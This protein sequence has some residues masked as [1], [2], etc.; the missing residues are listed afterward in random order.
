VLVGIALPAAFLMGERAAHGAA[1]ARPDASPFVSQ[2]AWRLTDAVVT[3]RG[4]VVA[5]R[6]G[7]LVSG[8]TVHATATSIGEGRY[9]RGRFQ[10]TGTL[11][12]PSA[13]SGR[14]RGGPWLVNGAWDVLDPHLSTEERGRSPYVAGG[15]L[16]AVLPF[17]PLEAPGMIQA[18]L[19]LTSL[20]PAG[21]RM[22]GQGT[23]SGNERFEGMLSWKVLEPPEAAVKAA[24]RSAWLNAAPL[25]ESRGGSAAPG[26]AVRLLREAMSA[27]GG[28]PLSQRSAP[29]GTPR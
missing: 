28:S 10:L 20:V 21:A 25:P 15:R 14:Q 23:F 8:Y 4:K 22:V 17:N 12:G 13:A 9:R 6:E 1:E 27:R 2:V 19:F 3:S 16:Q 24:D 11:F 29:A 5:V 26:T 18:S 7:I